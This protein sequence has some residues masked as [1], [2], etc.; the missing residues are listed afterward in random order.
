MKTHSQNI[1]LLWLIDSFII[2]FTTMSIYKKKNK[3]KKTECFVDLGVDLDSSH[4]NDGQSRNANNI[5]H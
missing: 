2:G 4:K 3:K 5:L 1:K